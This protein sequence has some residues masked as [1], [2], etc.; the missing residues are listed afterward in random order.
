MNSLWARRIRPHGPEADCDSEFRQEVKRDGDGI[1]FS[2]LCYM[3]G[4]PFF[5]PGY[6]EYGCFPLAAGD[7]KAA[8]H[9]DCDCDTGSGPRLYDT[10]PRDFTCMHHRAHTSCRS[11]LPFFRLLVNREGAPRLCFSWCSGKGADL[12]GLLGWSNTSST[13][14]ECRCGA[15]I[16]NRKFWETHGLTFGKPSPETN[17]GLPHPSL[18]LDGETRLPQHGDDCPS[19]A[20][21]VYSYEGRKRPGGNCFSTPLCPSSLDKCHSL[22][23]PPLSPEAQRCQ[24]LH[25][26]PTTPTP[27][28]QDKTSNTTQAKP[29]KLAK[30]SHAS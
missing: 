12:F 23:K 13:T 24:L 2:P 11:G 4:W 3:A 6:E 28:Y 10:A 21:R 15:T 1:W 19:N 17:S 5:G 8:S 29:A 25:P 18:L 14:A 9:L 27:H 26:A 30:P 16:T 22:L 20:I 7:V